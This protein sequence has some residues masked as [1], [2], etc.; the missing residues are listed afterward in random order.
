[1]ATL[2]RKEEKETYLHLAVFMN[3][4]AQI[5]FLTQRGAWVCKSALA[6]T[7][8]HSYKHFPMKAAL[9]PNLPP[10]KPMA[11]SILTSEEARTETQPLRKHSQGSLGFVSVFQSDLYTGLSINLEIIRQLEWIYRKLFLQS[12]LK[13]RSVELS[14]VVISCRLR[15][16]LRCWCTQRPQR[17]CLQIQ[18]TDNP[19]RLGC[20]HIF[21]LDGRLLPF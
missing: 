13:T 5:R 12:F 15:S 6:Q 7:D 11:Q 8:L 14:Q 21:I 19:L 17:F 18:N 4:E 20:T 1:M 9:K 16:N 10:L 3:S 2:K